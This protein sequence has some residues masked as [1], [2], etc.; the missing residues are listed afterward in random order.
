[1]RR[2]EDIGILGEADAQRG[3]GMGDSLERQQHSRRK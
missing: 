3:L 2:I 1:M